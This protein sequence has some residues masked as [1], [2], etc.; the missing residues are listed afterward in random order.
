MKGSELSKK[1]KNVSFSYFMPKVSNSLRPLDEN[2][3]VRGVINGYQGCFLY[4]GEHNQNKSTYDD[5][6]IGHL[7][8]EG[9]Q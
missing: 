5:K 2:L 9:D 8:C 1:A 3:I 7:L 4:V 6:G